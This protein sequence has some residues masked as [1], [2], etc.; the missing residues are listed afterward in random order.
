MSRFL[1]LGSI[2]DPG[3]PLKTD[4]T[5]ILSDAIR[6]MTQLRIEAQ[7][8]KESNKDLQEK[9]KELKVRLGFYNV[10]DR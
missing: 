8:L 5:A 4:K 6:M 10:N 9:I 3:R 2:L 7:K 1:E